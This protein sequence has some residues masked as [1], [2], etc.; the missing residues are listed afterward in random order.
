[1]KTK[2][3]QAVKALGYPGVVRGYRKVNR[4]VNVRINKT[5]RC[6]WISIDDVTVEL[7][8]VTA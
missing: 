6:W 3:G 2:L 1:M 5:G 7:V 8:K 4:M